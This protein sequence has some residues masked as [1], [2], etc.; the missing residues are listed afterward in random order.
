M[1]QSLRWD[2]AIAPLEDDPFT[3]CKSDLK[4]LDYGALAIPA[5]FSDVRPYCETVRHRETGLVVPN[6]A[7]C[8][9]GRPRAR[10]RATGRCGRASPARPAT[11]S[12]PRRMLATNAARW[13]DVL[14]AP[15]A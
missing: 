14:S 13:L 1:R 7:G 11:R 5:V 6:E 4:Y 15:G 3:R 8:V 10:W 2:F 12:M 9:G